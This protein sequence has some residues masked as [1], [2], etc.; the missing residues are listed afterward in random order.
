MF[1]N[2]SKKFITIYDWD[3]APKELKDLSTSGGDEDW[4][5]IIPIHINDKHFGVSFLQTPSFSCIGESQVIDL[6]DNND[7]VTHKI[8]IASH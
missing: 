8:Y 1:N 7:I 3:D 5:A 2:Y 6:H 4:I